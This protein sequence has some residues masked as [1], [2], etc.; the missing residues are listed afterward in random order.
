MENLDDAS[1]T[2]TDE[3]GDAFDLTVA[4][5]DTASFTAPDVPGEYPYVCT[6]HAGMTGSLVVG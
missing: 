1:H 6:F 4:P 5:G 2:V 3:A